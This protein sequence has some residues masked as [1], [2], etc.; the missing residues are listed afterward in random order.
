M[1]SPATGKEYDDWNAPGAVNHEGVEQAVK[2]AQGEAEVI[3]VEGSSVLY[4]EELRK[5]FDLKIFL[6]WIPMSECTA[7]SNEIWLCGMHRWKKSQ[8]TILN[9]QNSVRKRITWI[10]KCMRISCSTGEV[11][12]S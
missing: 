8:I 7:V 5:Q 3:L 11:T 1:V 2:E 6:I 10:R 12:T 9:L 4:S